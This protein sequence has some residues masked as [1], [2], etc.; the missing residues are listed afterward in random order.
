MVTK[1]ALGLPSQGSKPRGALAGSLGW[2]V[3]PYTKR[4]GFHYPGSG[5][6]QVHPIPGLGAHKG[7]LILSLSKSNEKM[8]SED[9][10]GEK[11]KKAQW[12]RQT[13]PKQCWLG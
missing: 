9:L 4:L 2:N 3:I 11:K 5:C 7:Q 6:I 10:G 12:G 8:S 1:T 13:G